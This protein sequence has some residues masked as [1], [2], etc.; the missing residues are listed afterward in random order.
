MLFC[1]TSIA[2]I[3]SSSSACRSA[4]GG[5]IYPLG[6][7]G[8][9]RAGDR[10]A[11]AVSALPTLDSCPPA[12]ALSTLDGLRFLP[13]ALPCGCEAGRVLAAARGLVPTVPALPT[14]L[15]LVLLTLLLALLALATPLAMLAVSG[16]G[17]AV[18]RVF[19]WG[20]VAL[21]GLGTG[22]VAL[23]CSWGVGLTVGLTSFLCS[24]GFT[25]GGDFDTACACADAGVGACAGVGECPCAG[26]GECAG[27][28]PC[29]GVGE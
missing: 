3:A 14:L 24:V 15:V 27:E 2:S 28:C 18:L 6:D 29:A 19:A 21:A 13:T 17:E 25:G 11:V 8:G 22:D 5:E 7:G 1:L 9:D 20:A 4:G 16:I 10:K 23:L 26:V 12:P